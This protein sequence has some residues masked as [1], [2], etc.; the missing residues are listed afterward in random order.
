M[1][2]DILNRGHFKTG[3]KFIP[4][5]AKISLYFNDNVDINVKITVNS[6]FS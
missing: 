1:C 3:M 4:F 2:D 5:K 6:D